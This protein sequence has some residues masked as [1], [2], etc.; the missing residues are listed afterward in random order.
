MEC[1]MILHLGHASCRRP[2]I[3][4]MPYHCRKE[5][6]KIQLKIWDVSDRLKCFGLHMKRLYVHF[7][8][9]PCNPWKRNGRIRSETR[10]LKSFFHKIGIVSI[11]SV[12]AH[13][14]NLKGFDWNVLFQFL[15]LR[16][17]LR[18][19]TNTIC[20]VDCPM[21]SSFHNRDYTY[22][23]SS[24]ICVH[25][26]MNGKQWAWCHG[27]TEVGTFFYFTIYARLFSSYILR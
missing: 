14:Q 6:F 12:N 4:I 27:V 8:F 7:I 18:K 22:T 16:K 2:W 24:P 23:E 1:G 26:V 20:Y 15:T 13:T 11:K 25:I 17:P 3:R 21:Y 19:Q 5:D 10:C 9:S